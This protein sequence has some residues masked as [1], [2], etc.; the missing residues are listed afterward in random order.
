MTTTDPTIV[1]KY[2]YLIVDGSEFRV[3][4]EECGEG[5]PLICMH[6]AGAEGRQWRHLIE[7]SD[8]TSRFRVLVPDLPFHGKSLPPA[9]QPWWEQEYRLT[10][11]FFEHF[12]VEFSHRLG[13]DQPVYLGCWVGGHLAPQDAVE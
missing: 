8:I 1:G 12:V 11:E 13:L 5:I 3:Y 9:G 2:T 10:K 6:T 4:Y 7:D